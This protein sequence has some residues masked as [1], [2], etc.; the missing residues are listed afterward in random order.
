[1]SGPRVLLLDEPSLSCI[2][3]AGTAAEIRDRGAMLDA[4]LGRTDV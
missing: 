4:Y 2:V 3:A 1:M